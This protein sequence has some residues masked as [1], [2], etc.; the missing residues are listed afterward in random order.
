MGEL[1]FDGINGKYNNKVTDIPIITYSMW[2][3][4]LFIVI[5]ILVPISHCCVHDVFAANTTKHFLNDLT[6]KRLLA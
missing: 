3:T 6:D 2:K 1:G 4:L 5:T